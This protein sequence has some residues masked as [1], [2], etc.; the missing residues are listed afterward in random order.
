M[1]HAS[2]TDNFSCSICHEE[3]MDPRPLPCGHCYCGPPRDCLNKLECEGGTMVCAMC[4]EKFNLR[5]SQIKPLY[6]I[7]DCFNQEKI[8]HRDKNSAELFCE[9]HA[10]MECKLWC[11]Q[12]NVKLC[13]ACIRDLHDEHTL[14]DLR[15]HLV[16]KI[17]RKLG[18]NIQEGLAKFSKDLAKT[19]S[20]G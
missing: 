2:N 12:C 16:Q 18:T 8:S 20:I 6:G 15:K 5:A 13:E 1:A 11:T 10:R 14:R 19:N 4:R 3:F 9:Q 17:E 7:R